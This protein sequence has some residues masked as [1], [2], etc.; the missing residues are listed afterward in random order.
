[1]LTATVCA[2]HGCPDVAVRYGRCE[3]HALAER[4]RRRRVHA[5]LEGATPD[6]AGPRPGSLRALWRTAR[7]GCPHLDAMAAGGPQMA[8]VGRLAAVCE[9]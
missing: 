5:Q 6:G 9:D 1:M 4:R 2:V 7:C 8:L 3:T